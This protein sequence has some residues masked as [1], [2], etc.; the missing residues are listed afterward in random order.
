MCHSEPAR[1]DNTAPRLPEFEHA[2]VAH[3]AGAAVND[4]HG[5]AGSTNL[6]ASHA[7]DD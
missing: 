5:T 3:V 6:V 1:P 4:E 2:V 7:L